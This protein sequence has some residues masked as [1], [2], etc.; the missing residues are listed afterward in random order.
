MLDEPP[1]YDFFKHVKRALR[2]IF[3]FDYKLGQSAIE[4]AQQINQVWGPN[5]ARESTVRQWLNKFRSGDF[6]L[7]DEPH[8]GRPKAISDEDFKG[9]LKADP[10]QTVRE[11]AEKLGVGKSTVADGLERIGKVKKLDSWVPH[12][13]SDRQDSARLEVPSALLS[14]QK[15]PVFGPNCHL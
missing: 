9:M 13:R 10:S 11:I 7:E 15:R 4:T 1:F 6:S 3:F 5:S 2:T 8:S 14:Q 12:N